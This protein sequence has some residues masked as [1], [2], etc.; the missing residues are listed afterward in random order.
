[1]R[2][3][4]DASLTQPREE[5]LHIVSGTQLHVAYHQEFPDE[6]EGVDDGRLLARR[7][8]R[9]QVGGVARADSFKIR[10]NSTEK[11]NGEHSK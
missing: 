6:L 8:G 11:R 2:V 3:A 4:G 5:V 10:H 7:V 9:Q 1:M